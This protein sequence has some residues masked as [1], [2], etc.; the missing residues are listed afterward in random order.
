MKSTLLTVSEE[1][2]PQ[3]TY[4]VILKQEKEGVYQ[5]TVWGLADCQATGATKEAALKSINEILTARLD[6]TEVIVQKI[7]LLKLENP[8]MEWAGMYKDNPLFN[9]MIAEIESYRNELDA[10][11]DEYYRK[12]DEE[13]KKE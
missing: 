6:N 2:L 12:M 4:S 13:D 7:P 9:D 8:W 11:M 5:A 1:N 10:E 3:V